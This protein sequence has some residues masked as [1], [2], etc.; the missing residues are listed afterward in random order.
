MKARKR[1]SCLVVVSLSLPILLCFVGCGT[2]INYK[3]DFR[4]GPL[5][6]DEETY[7][8]QTLSETADRCSSKEEA[9]ALA[10]FQVR[11]PANTFGREMEG[12]FV[13]KSRDEGP[14]KVTLLYSGGM[15]IGEI[16]K[17]EPLSYEATVETFK[18][19]N[20]AAT[21]DPQPLPFRIEIKGNEGFGNEPGFNNIRGQKLPRP[22]VIK[23]SEPNGITYDIYGD[24]I[25]VKDLIGVAE[26]MY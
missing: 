8:R 11:I 2:S 15:N 18:Q 26:S 16:Q 21:S 20:A 25:R 19:L 6:G 7:A 10:S 5:S 22:G 24:G 17:T 1:I 14:K 12:I 9:S 13:Q 23:W 3:K 4:G